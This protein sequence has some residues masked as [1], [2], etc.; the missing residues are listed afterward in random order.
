MD[1]NELTC[2][3]EID[4]Q[5]L[6]NLWSPKGTVWG[7]GERGGLGVWDGSVLKLGCNNGCITINIINFTEI[8]KKR[9]DFNQGGVIL[10]DRY[11]M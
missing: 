5:T 10:A 9:K 11:R 6:K 7:G 1:T 4:S 8:F 2:R 3:T